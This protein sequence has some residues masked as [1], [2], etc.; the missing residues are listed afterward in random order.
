M[1]VIIGRGS[2]CGGRGLRTRTAAQAVDRHGRDDDRP[3]DHV[4][5]GRSIAGVDASVVQSRDQQ[6]A[7]ERCRARCPRRPRGCRRRS[8]RPR[9]PEAPRHR[10]SRG[11]PARQL[12][13]LH[14]ARQARRQ[15]RQAVDGQLHHGHVDAAKPSRRLARTNR[16]NVPP[17]DAVAQGQRQQDR[18][19]EEHPDA[20][21]DHQ[22]ARRRGSRAQDA[23]RAIRASRRRPAGRPGYPRRAASPA[24]E[25]SSESR[26]SR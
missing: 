16:V 3:D 4:P 1:R 23:G 22:P 5:A 17:Q 9:S 7:D 24:L 20:R 18:Q 14:H 11:R 15:T 21:R 26:G 2:C 8:R 13:E 6:A 19:P 25:R 12:Q 10:P